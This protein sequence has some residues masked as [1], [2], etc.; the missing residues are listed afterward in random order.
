MSQG[1]VKSA[2]AFLKAAV[3]NNYISEDERKS[4]TR[5]ALDSQ[6]QQMRLLEET[7]NEREAK[8]K[9]IDRAYSQACIDTIEHAFDQLTY[10]EQR[11]VEANFLETSN[12]ATSRENTLN[13][14]DGLQK[15]SYPKRFNFGRP[16]KFHSLISQ[17]YRGNLVSKTLR[18][19]KLRQEKLG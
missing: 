8:A 5:K 11:S 2:P 19:T 17:I 10:E 4:A 13:G 15:W 6:A 16:G 3:R 9:E 7:K 18:H 14:M 12:L 1:R